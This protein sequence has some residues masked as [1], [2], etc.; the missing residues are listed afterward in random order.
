VILVDDGIATGSTMRAAI[1][2]V[3]AARASK[4][5]VGVPVAAPQTIRELESLVDEVAAVLTPARLG[6]VGAWYRDF[7][8]T[9][10]DEVRRLLRESR[11]R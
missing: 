8:Q 4:V 10:D 11:S 6:A 2:A 7:A 1:E 3:Q 9:R 5:S